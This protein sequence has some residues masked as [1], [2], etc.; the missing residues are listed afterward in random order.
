MNRSKKHGVISTA[1]KK[2]FGRTEQND[3]DGGYFREGSLDARNGSLVE[4]FD[5]PN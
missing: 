3:K 4:A 2:C 1:V 5:V